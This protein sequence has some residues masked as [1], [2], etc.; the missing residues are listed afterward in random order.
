MLPD[1]CVVQR[2]VEHDFNV[3][4]P[5]QDEIERLHR[6]IIE[7]LS[8]NIITEESKQFYINVIQRLYDEH[9]VQG[10]VLGCTGKEIVS[11]DW[12]FRCSLS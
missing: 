8:N 5:Q 1:S 10:V 11:F 4:F 6:I 12:I 7:E 2:L 3:I 9:Q